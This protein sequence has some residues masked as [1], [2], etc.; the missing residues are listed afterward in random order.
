MEF[1]RLFEDNFDFAF[2]AATYN[3]MKVAIRAYEQFVKENE[4]FFSFDK[5]KSLFGRLRAYA[6]ER[7]FYQSAFKP[8]AG[9]SVIVK[10][11]NNYGY[12]ALCIETEDFIV[13]IGHTD[14]AERLLTAS[15]YKKEFA[16]ANAGLG[17]QLSFDFTDAGAGIVEGK[18]YAEITYGYHSGEI[19]HLNI[20]VPSGDYKGIEYSINLLENIQIYERY[21]PEQLVEEEVVSL[22][23]A[24]TKKAGN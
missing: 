6:V 19:T 20:V 13:N 24:L 22:K 23:A 15:A 18:K 21:V 9:Y 12:N 7:Q 4:D 17:M 5:G 10:P 1:A 16:K 3:N 8:R 2:N 11:V 14:S